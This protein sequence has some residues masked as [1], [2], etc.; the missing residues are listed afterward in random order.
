MQQKKDL[1]TFLSFF[2]YFLAGVCLILFII[3]AMNFDFSAFMFLCPFGLVICFGIASV[4]LTK[5]K[6][7]QRIISIIQEIKK[8]EKSDIKQLSLI[9]HLDYPDIVSIAKLSIN[10]GL[11]E[12]YEIV[13][14]WIALKS[15]HL[16]EGELKG[17]K[18]EK[19]ITFIKCP[20]CGAS[21]SYRDK[22]CSYCGTKIK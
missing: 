13:S 5:S 15:L 8:N 1:F 18:D 10:K 2:F 3:N 17:N 20:G 4:L 11:L 9:Y 16:Q 14:H 12:Q 21:I 19:S 6:L 7:Y 22:E